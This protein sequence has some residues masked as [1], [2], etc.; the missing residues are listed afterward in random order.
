[1]AESLTFHDPKTN[2]DYVLEFDRDSVRFAED[3]GVNLVDLTDRSHIKPATLW[4]Q[5]FYAALHKH[6]PMLTQDQSDDMW[7]RIP[8]K[9]DVFSALL[10]MFQVPYTALLGD[11]AE[12]DSKNVIAI[13]LPNKRVVKAPTKTTS[14]SATE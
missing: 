1:M 13:K 11:K 8:N 14:K 12:G 7:S 10:D 2:A 4:S 3:L 5:M 9:A 6:Q